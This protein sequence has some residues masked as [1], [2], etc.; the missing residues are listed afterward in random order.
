MAG[1]GAKGKPVGDGRLFSKYSIDL[2][3]TSL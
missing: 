2:Y 3:E 1:E